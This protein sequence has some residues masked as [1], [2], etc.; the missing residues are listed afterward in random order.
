MS[1]TLPIFR[2][3]IHWATRAAHLLLELWEERQGGGAEVKRQKHISVSANWWKYIFK[4]NAFNL[5][6]HCTFYSP[7]F[8]FQGE[9]EAWLNYAALDFPSRKR[10]S[11]MTGRE[12]A[13][14]C[15]H[16]GMRWRKN[17]HLTP[18]PVSGVC[19]KNTSMMNNEEDNLKK[20]V[21]IIFSH[22]ICQC[23]GCDLCNFLE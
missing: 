16:T 21:Y 9:E 23:D 20:K 6:L 17:E 14:D 1:G 5:L 19:M 12:L 11:R 22:V 2:I 18:S 7:N 8:H 13:Q 15:F 3:K 4:K 10:E